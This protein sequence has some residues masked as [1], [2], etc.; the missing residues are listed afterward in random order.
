MSEQNEVI[1]EVKEDSTKDA[2]FVDMQ[3]LQMKSN[4]L[5]ISLQ[6][7]EATD[8]VMI[9]DEDGK[10]IQVEVSSIRGDEREIVTNTVFD[11][12][13]EIKGMTK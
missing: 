4:L 2:K 9:E 7:L 10:T 5:A 13:M 12:F 11:T 8:K 1:N 3:Q 6:V